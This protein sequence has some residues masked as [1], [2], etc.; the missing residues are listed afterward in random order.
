VA[1]LHANWSYCEGTSINFPP[2]HGQHFGGRNELL[3]KTLFYADKSLLPA[4]PHLSLIIKKGFGQDMLTSRV[5]K[6]TVESG[7]IAANL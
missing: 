5:L 7:C 6:G 2:Y 4:L 3:N 1:G